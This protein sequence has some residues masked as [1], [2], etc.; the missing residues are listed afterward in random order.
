MNRWLWACL[1]AALGLTL[2]VSGLLVPAHLRAVDSK[3]LALAGQRSRSLLDE[4][5]GFLERN[6]VG[7]AWALLEAAQLEL[8]PGREQ[9]GAAVGN[10]ALSHRQWM[11]WG[12]PDPTLERLFAGDAAMTRGVAQPIV[13]YLVRMENRV[14]ILEFMRTSNDPLV[15]NLLRCRDLTN[16]VVFPAA[17]STSG[18]AY[19]T[20]LATAGLLARAHRFSPK[21]DEA[22]TKQTSDALRGENGQ[23]FEQ[24]LLDL[25]SLGQR[26]DWT[27]LCSFLEH[28]DDPEVLRLL[29]QLARRASAQ[30]PVSRLPVLFAAVQ[31]SGQPAQV[32]KYLME[33]SQ[34]GLGDLG[35]SLRYGASGVKEV[36]QRQQRVYRGGWRTSITRYDP[37]GAFFYLTLDYCRLMPVFALAVKWLLYLAGGFFLAAAF[38]YARPSVAGPEEGAGEPAPAISSARELLFALGFLLVVLLVSEPFLAQESQKVEFPFRLRLPLVGAVVPAGIAQATLQSMNTNNLITMLLFFVLQALIYVACVAKVG[39]IGRQN[40]SPSLKLKLIENEDH[41]FDAGL[42]LGFV[43]TIISLILVSFKFGGLSL[44]AGYSSTSF[45]IIFVCILKIFHVRPLRRK[46]LLENEA[47]S[48]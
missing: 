39:E 12:G 43:G 3:V 45:G 11:L 27:Q 36:L 24:V 44:M 38:Q 9:L 41:L 13:E 1:S 5:A 4:A 33:F 47:L 46:L 18:Q 40:V 14:R 6:Q 15:Q 32:V 42:Y 25:M 22:L 37:F 21:L 28:V 2:V 16:T 8:L 10:F 19:E 17:N 34:N 48:A 20:A 26:L 23:R 35:Y 31:L 29:G 7:P 30:K